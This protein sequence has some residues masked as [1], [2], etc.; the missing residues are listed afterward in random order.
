MEYKTYKKT[1]DFESFGILELWTRDGGSAIANIDMM[2]PKVQEQSQALE[3]FNCHGNPKRKVVFYP[4][5]PYKGL[6]TE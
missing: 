6:G 1:F 3:T 4:H 5:F 2:L